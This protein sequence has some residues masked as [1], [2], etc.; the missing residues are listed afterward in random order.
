MGRFSKKWYVSAIPF[1]VGIA[2]LLA[3]E[4][5]NNLAI[6]PT[7]NMSMLGFFSHTKRISNSNLSKIIHRL[8][9][10]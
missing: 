8:E 9:I 4:S 1:C 3:L 10:N 2:Y 6:S 7:E 5:A